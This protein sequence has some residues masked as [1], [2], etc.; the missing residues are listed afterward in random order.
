MAENTARMRRH[1]VGL[2]E[3]IAGFRKYMGRTL[4]DVEVTGVEPLITPENRQ[5]MIV[6]THRSHLD[7]LLIASELERRSI[8]N[9]RFAAGDNLTRLPVLGNRFLKMGA[10]SV[11]RGKASQRSYLFKLT[12]Q[13]KKLITSG[14]TVVVFPEGGRSYSGH[15]LDLKSGIT[16]AAVVAQQENPDKEICYLPVSIT[17]EQPPEVPYFQKL[18]WGKKQRDE[19]K[20]KFMR[21]IGEMTYYG[22]DIYA[23]WKRGIISRFGVKYGKVIIA[24]DEPM[25]VNKM[26]NIEELYRAKAPNSF[27][28]NRVAIKECAEILEKRF[29]EIHTL[30]PYNI[31]GYLIQ[32][33]TGASIEE[34]AGKATDL[35]KTLE[36]K[37]PVYISSNE[38]ADLVH[39]GLKQLKKNKV[40]RYNNKTY[41]VTRPDLLTYFAAAVQDKIERGA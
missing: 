38:G 27:M 9:I 19:G 2:K 29:H 20:N 5:F 34:L 31:V 24:F 37:H 13:V 26:A 17:Y 21:F 3:N 12:E 23:F 32:E 33:N 8:P 18:L 40:I 35:L 10:F 15:M 1:T 41:S 39:E 16:G 6:S 30:F 4:G 7:Y 22:A 25:P 36:D 14:D 28:A 11:Y